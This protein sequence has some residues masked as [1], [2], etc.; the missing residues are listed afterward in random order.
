MLKALLEKKAKI[1]AEIRAKA[2]EMQKGETAELRAAWDSL[3]KDFDKVQSDLAIAERSAE[4]EREQRSVADRLRETA[5][6]KAKVD[7]RSIGH[8]EEIAIELRAQTVGTGSNGGFLA[9]SLAA[10]YLE[11]A[12]NAFAP[13]RER[14]ERLVTS[15]GAVIP[16][17]SVNDLSNSGA[18]RA[19][20][21]AATDQDLVLASQTLSAFKIDSGFIRVSDELLEDSQFDL[22]GFVGRAIAE[23]IGRR[24]QTRLATGTGTGQALGVV[25]ASTLGRT[26]AAA[27][28]ITAD[29]LIDL[30]YSVN[31]PYRTN[32][33]FLMRSTT[34][35][36]VRKL[37]DSQGQYLW[38]P[39]IAA[40]QPE[41]ILGK[42]VIAV[43]DMAAIATAQRTVVFGDMSKMLLRE[44]NSM[45]IKKLVERYADTGQVAW[46]ASMRF[47][48][49]LNDAG[50]G[51]IKHLVQA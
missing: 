22:E 11:M 41:T 8:G 9:P 38:N 10:P 20:A 35:A 40:G 5:D 23:R 18:D 44:V 17:P 4:M 48:S 51:A 6:K 31:E 19:E 12:M 15:S 1:A 2:D 27:A 45:K 24:M 26:A 34:I 7:L 13:L 30:F 14:F 42:P 33:V 29:E 21:A 43:D 25:T 28:A 36:A 3:N 37:K 50:A 47:D 16:L 46:I 39:A 32:G 49:R